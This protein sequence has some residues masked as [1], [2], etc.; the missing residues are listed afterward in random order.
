MNNKFKLLLAILQIIVGI[1][2][3]VVF[4]KNILTGGKTEMTVLALVM[5]ILGL[6][7]GVRGVCNI[8]KP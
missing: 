5:M 3:A 8:G 6:V 1:L 2:A 7:Y 4:V